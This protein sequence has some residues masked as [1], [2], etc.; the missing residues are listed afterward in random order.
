MQVGAVRPRNAAATRAAILASAR[1][2]FAQ[3]GYDG[4]GVRE[5]AGRAG[6]TAMLVNRYFGSKEQLFAEVVA[7]TMMTPSVLTE[8]VT[9]SPELSR[10]LAAA[11]VEHTGAAPLDGFLIML[12]SIANPR[13][14]E[15]W[16]GQV[17]AHHQRQ[18]T[19]ALGGARA[20]ERA[21]LVLAMLAG[22]QVMRQMVGLS[23]LADAEPGVLAR[24]LAPV[25]RQLVE[26]GP[27]AERDPATA[28]LIVFA[29]LPG[30]GK[31][32][33]ARALAQR[34][35]AIWLRADSIEQAIKDSGVVPGDLKDAGYR[36]A[37]AVAEDN[38]RLGRDVIGDCVNDWKI[39]RDAWQ[40]LADRAGAEAVWVEVVCGDP[41]E[42]R[43]RV[44]RRA[45]AV[46]GLVLPTWDEAVGRE[47]HGW[48]RER[49]VVDTAGRSVDD[50]LEPILAAL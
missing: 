22:F 16:R 14:A 13:A 11:L 18:M 7:E 39:A 49:V 20:S 32:T 28:R 33:L 31:S 4:V 5:I 21:A 19:E 37:Y 8:A 9:G 25:F 40:A 42:H 44:E 41:A 17:E 35:G 23:A 46:P 12:R 29:G 48:D 15:I 6:V 34:T 1:A 36:A 10:A 50:C 26:A 47:Y 3:A 45:N 43:R 38:L 2:A 27:D 24:L 30:S